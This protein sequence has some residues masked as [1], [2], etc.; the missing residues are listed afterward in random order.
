MGI[1]FDPYDYDSSV[2]DDEIAIIDAFFESLQMGKLSNGNPTVDITSVPYG[3]LMTMV[4]TDKRWVY[5]GSLT[6]PP[7]TQKIYWNVV[8]RVYPIKQEHLD[9][10]KK[11]L[12][13]EE[14][15]QPSKMKQG[16]N[17]RAVQPYK[18]QDPYLMVP[19]PPPVV[20]EDPY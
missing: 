14:V 9:Q 18:K 8:E 7:C 11:L 1:I 2:S 17:Y 13:A 6:T 4:H 16:G 5:Q 20:K 12:R 10:F 15:A 19:P 3:Q